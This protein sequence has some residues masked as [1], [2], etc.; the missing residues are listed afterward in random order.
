MGRG[1]GS[2][3][4]LV[5]D[6]DEAFRTFACTLL[7]EAGYETSAEETGAEALAAVQRE[8]FPLVVLD[9]HLRDISGYEVCRKIREE[10]GDA[11][12]VIFVS[13]E[14]VEAFDRVAGLRLGGDDYLTKPFAPDELL[15]RV[16]RLLCRLEA[17]AATT[18]PHM[19]TP[20]ELEILRSLAEGVSQ[21]E[22]AAEL[23]LSSNTVAR[24]IEHILGKLGVHSRAQAVAFAYRHG[25]LGSLL[26]G[27]TI[28]S[29]VANAVVS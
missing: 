29:G 25:L 10:F 17:A 2:G 18:G 19:L 13:G 24:H 5:V 20:R 26:W 23:V 7:R 8:R 11:V 12:G 15:A 28:L 4:V 6:D 21:K 14:R 22:I 3:P 27:A 1:S 9:V 16:E